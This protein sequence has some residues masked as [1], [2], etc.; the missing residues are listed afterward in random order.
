MAISGGDGSI[1][2][3]TQVDQ[4]G[5]KRGMASMK[6]GIAGLS[7]S[8]TKI[9]AAIGVAFGVG[10]LIKF[11]K[12]AV[13]LASDLQEVQ[14]VVDVAFGDM[15]YRMEQFADTA[16]ETFGISKL[17]AKQTGSSYMA[18]AK[19]MQIADDAAADM[20]LTLTGLSADMAS[21]Y[22]IRQEEAK[23]ALASVFTGETET[24]KRYGIL[25]TEVNLQEFARQQ[26]IT[27]SINAMTQQEKVMLRYQYI[28]QATQLAQ[29][30]FVRTQDSWANQ[31]RIL[32]E[33]WKEMA[34]IFGEAFMAIGLLV[35][36]VI[37][38]I[39]VGLTK[40]AEAARTVAQWIYKAFTGKELKSSTTVTQNQATSLSGVGSSAEKAAD[41]MS[42][43]GGATKK[44]T[45]EA[46][47]SLAGFD[48]LQI[49]TSN[50]ADSAGSAGSALGGIGG[51]GGIGDIGGG[52]TFE[53]TGGFEKE[54]EFSFLQQRL[55]E[56]QKAFSGIKD[57]E[58]TNLTNSLA[59]LKEPLQ[60]L[61][62]IGWDVLL[63]GIENVIVPLTEFTVEEALPRYFETLSNKL[64]LFKTILDEGF[65][66]YKQFYDEFLKPIASYAADGFLQLWDTLNENLEEFVS[67]VENSTSWQDLQTILG[68]IYDVLEPVVKLI[69]D[70]VVWV[71]K[72][73]INKA[74][75]DLKWRF[76][77]IEDALGLIAAIINGDFGGAW[78]HLKDLMWDNRIDKA[79]ENL[80]NLRTAFDD[81]KTKVEEFVE[82]WKLKIDDMVESWKTKISAWWTDN[83][84]PWFTLEKWS[85][86]FSHIGTSLAN[87]IVGAGGFVETWKSNITN[88]WND[89][90]SP[91]FTTDKWKKVFDNIVTSISNFFTAEDGFVKT[92][93]TKIS[94]WWTEDVAP[95]FT[96]E[97][98][99]TLGTNL[100]D[101]LMEGLNGAIGGIA[102][103]VNKMIDGFQKLINGAIGLINDFIK[104]WN[105]V[106]D[107]TPLL[108]S[109]SYIKALDLSK[110]KIPGY[111]MG[112][113]VPPNKPFLG[114]LGDNKN[115][116]EVVSPISTLKQAFAEAMIEMGGSF[117]GGN[118]EVVLEIDGRE[119]GRAVVEQG[120]R[121]NRRIGTRLVI[122]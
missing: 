12:Q 22:N 15:A 106:A 1:I 23:T 64:R 38:S 108:P 95:W 85:E 65:N 73:E 8:F 9:G 60:G 47:K 114:V 32:S 102:T 112:T 45:K 88:W 41:G 96:I 3:T 100:K 44:A 33:R 17:T 34:T 42:D 79:K 43:L 5:L 52:M 83:V 30:D 93:K 35:L 53:E 24:L 31:T 19:G 4:T 98:W 51:V 111:A 39:I 113:V 120:N 90:V 16:I 82:D 103:T 81:V 77:D 80:D 118:T 40:V 56:L 6:S 119:F 57:I 66:V 20:A 70:F 74:W 91:W 37:N 36:P 97:K 116:T 10:A 69:I 54:K 28:L 86:V 63:W 117:G 49:I 61:A 27:K 78:E 84:E 59:L 115:E 76:L 29:G 71:G 55:D 89:D 2:L 25:I 99:K 11:G 58:L 122:A 14:N 121:E 48:D 92:W 94:D 109:I 104:G 46:Q 105:T 26:G 110:Y 72:F 50:I 101:G 21:F 75:T 87:F 13:Q 107:V 68:L 7:K 62:K 18:M 67:I